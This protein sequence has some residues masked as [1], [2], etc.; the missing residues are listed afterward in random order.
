VQAKRIGLHARR[1]LSDDE[2][3]T[4]SAEWLKIPAQ[5]EFSEEGIIEMSL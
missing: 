3:A 5:D 2:I 4:I 1:S